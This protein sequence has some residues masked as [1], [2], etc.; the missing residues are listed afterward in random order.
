VLLAQSGDRVTIDA[1]V[2]VVEQQRGRVLISAGG[3]S[4]L[5]SESAVFHMF[6]SNEL[7]PRRVTVDQ[8]RRPWWAR[9]L[10]P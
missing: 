3:A 7:E 8:L 2:I 6:P 4:D 9:G 5:V 1:R 10:A